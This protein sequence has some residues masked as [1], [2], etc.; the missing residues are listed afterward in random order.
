MNVFL[1]E[2]ETSFSDHDL[3]LTAL[4]HTSYANEHRDERVSYERL[5]FLGDSVLGL[6][7]SDY[8]YKKH[9]SL[10]EGELS[11]LR[12]AVVCEKSLS[13]IAVLLNLGERIYLGRGEEQSRSR[14]RASI[15]ADVVEAIIGAVYLDAGI[16]KANQVVLHLLEE[17]LS[18]VSEV[19]NQDYKT[20][21]QELVQKNSKTPLIYRVVA[22]NGPEHDKCFSV[23]VEHNGVVLG[24]GE[25]RS[26]KSAE[27]Q[28]A[29]GAL[30]QKKKI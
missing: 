11:R 3:F 2:L 7:V 21:L 12:S 26:K 8:L 14:Q 18:A 22:E 9:P 6:C 19:E 16:E 30:Q 10:P 1:R 28:A 20:R 4:T 24:V 27:Q 5:E 25:G 23:S 29:K 13:E 15:L 17:K